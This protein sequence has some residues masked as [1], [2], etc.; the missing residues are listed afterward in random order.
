MAKKRRTRKKTGKTKLTKKQKKF[1]NALEDPDVT[2]VAEASRK[3]GY[4]DVSS[5]YRSLEKPLIQSALEHFLKTLEVQGATDKKV[6]LRIAQ[7]LDA[8]K[9]TDI[10]HHT[11]HKF[12]ETVLKVKQFVT[13]GS[14]EPTQDNRKQLIFIIGDEGKTGKEALEEII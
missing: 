4:A 7:G 11:R 2:S 5:G 9:T 1:V 12:V 14:K 6:A 3:A 10:D 8:K 13:G